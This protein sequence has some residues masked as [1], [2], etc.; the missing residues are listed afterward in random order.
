METTYKLAVLRAIVD[1]VIEHPARNPCNGLH[2]IP[3]IDLA[4]RVLAYYWR[5]VA[6]KIPQG[7]SNRVIIV[8]SVRGLQQ[9]APALSGVD[10]KSR[11]AGLSL[12]MSITTADNLP[13]EIV[14]ALVVIRRTLIEQP[15]QYLPNVGDQR[16]DVFSMLTDGTDP[17]A[18]YSTHRTAANRGKPF[19]SAST[20]LELLDREPSNVVLSARAYEEIAEMRFWL[21]D[22]I[23]LRWAQQCTEWN[24]GDSG[25]PV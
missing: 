1:F 4:R 17:N 9:A 8:K 5:P 23:T 10:F 6:D 25:I 15:F 21:R 16:L 3:V 11:Q 7:K 14:E 13:R 2:R 18:D 24:G 20:W 12:A 22:A 19:N